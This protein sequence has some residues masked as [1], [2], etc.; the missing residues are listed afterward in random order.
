[1]NNDITFCVR[2]NC[3]NLNCRRNIANRHLFNLDE[4]DRISM[5]DFTN[6]N[7]PNYQNEYPIKLEVDNER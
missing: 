4:D 3:E 5:C 7:A 6:C 2:E 1:M